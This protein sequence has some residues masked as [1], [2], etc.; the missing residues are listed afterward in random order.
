MPCPR[1]SHLLAMLA[2]TL[3]LSLCITTPAL[4]FEGGDSAGNVFSDGA[5]PLSEGAVVEHDLYWFGE[6]LT[7]DA[8][9]VR[10]D[11][12]AAGRSLVLDGTAVT[13]NVRAVGQTLSL[14]GVKA[15]NLTCAGQTLDV[16]ET[17]MVNAAYLAGQ[18]VTFSGTAATVCLA[19]QTVTIDGTITGDA[20]VGAKTVVIGP[21]ANI[22]GTLRVDAASEPAIPSTAKVG[23]LSFTQ[24]TDDSD[25]A[26]EGVTTGILGLGLA[27]LLFGIASGCLVALLLT[28][29]LPVAVDGAAACVRKRTAPLLVSGVVGVLVII[30]AFVAL[31]VLVATIPLAVA[32][33]LGFV[34]LCLVAVPFSGAS[35]ARLCFPGWN[36]FGAAAAGGAVLGLAAAIPLLGIVVSFAAVVY[37]VGYLVQ[38]VWA[39]IHAPT[40]REGEEAAG[41]ALPGAPADDGSPVPPQQASTDAVGR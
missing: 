28:L 41:A 3:L 30:P 23:S 22:E 34:A 8:A 19:G 25:R 20:S 2:L 31:L 11:V 24:S 36:R 12:I 37:L 33:L 32:L 40:A 10:G 26:T 4:A 18:D 38:S 6:S 13:G 29:V 15:I 5:S 14:R 39:G 16:D 17:T 27:K 7:L 9:D 1:H 21:N 35:L